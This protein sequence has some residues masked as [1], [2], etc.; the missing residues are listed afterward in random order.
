M[1]KTTQISIRDIDEETLQQSQQSCSFYAEKWLG[2]QPYYYQIPFLDDVNRFKAATFSRQLGKTFSIALKASQVINMFPDSEV[3]ITAQNERRAFE[4]YRMVKWMQGLNPITKSLLQPKNDKMHEMVLDT[5]SRVTYY[6][7]GTE[8]KSIRGATLDMLLMDEADFIPD[9]VFTATLPTISATGGG[10]MMTSTPNKPFSMF[11]EIFMDGWNARLKMEGKLELLPDEEPYTEPIGRVYGFS[12][13]H[14]DWTHG[15]KVINPKTGIPQI[16][17][18]VVNILKA[19]DMYLYE[20]EYLAWWPEEGST[21]FPLKAIVGACRPNNERIK[22]PTHYV[23]G[24]DLGRINDFTAI[25]IYE[26]NEHRDSAMIVDSFRIR[27][28][29]WQAIFGHILHYAR[30]W[31]VVEIILDGN[32][33]GDIMNTWLASVSGQGATF[34]VVPVPLS[35]QS[36]AKLYNNLKMG[37]NTGRIRIHAKNIHDNMAN[38]ELIH[39]LIQ[40]QAEETDTGKIKI[41]APSGKHDDMADA[42]A[43]GAKILAFPDIMGGEMAAGIVPHQNFFA[44]MAVSEEDDISDIIGEN[45]FVVD[46]WDMKPKYEF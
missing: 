9:L 24:L 27:K 46:D 38:E 16:D 3:G 21:F 37:I 41:H 43:L 13:Y 25:V 6:A 1:A 23:M 45:A 36:K 33:V 32:N 20:R 35:I 14:Y 26:V 17:E 28:N 15:T 42:A 12:S 5:G 4:I 40:I 19:K 34:N 2:L 11:H 44:E 30:K 7:S 31:S 8:G 39:E 22:P 10:I 29:N 18:K